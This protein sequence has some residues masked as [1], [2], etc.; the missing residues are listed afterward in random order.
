MCGRFTLRVPLTVLIDEFELGVAP[1][2]LLLFEAKYNIPPTTEIPVI[3]HVDNR[4]TLSLM[5]RGM[6]PACQSHVS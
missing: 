3:R 4:R 5:R 2:E 6:A 1:D